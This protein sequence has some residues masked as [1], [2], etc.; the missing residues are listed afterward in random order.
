MNATR[1]SRDS[2][3]MPQQHVHEDLALILELRTGELS[4]RKHFDF[5]S[6]PGTC[7]GKYLFI[8]CLSANFEAHSPSI[9]LVELC[10]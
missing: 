1:M 7:A 8:V 4:S 10:R 2:Q 9:S 6:V 5:E 3:I